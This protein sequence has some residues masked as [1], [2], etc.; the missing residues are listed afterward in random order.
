M[1]DAPISTPSPPPDTGDGRKG[2]MNILL[3]D[4]RGPLDVLF[5]TSVVRALRQV[6]PRAE[7][8]VAVTEAARD[9]LAHHPCVRETLIFDG[10]NTGRGVT[11]L[12]QQI[13]QRQ[14]DRVIAAH[15]AYD[16]CLVAALSG[17]ARIEMPRESRFRHL[18][19]NLWGT[20]RHPTESNRRLLDDIGIPRQLLR[21]PELWLDVASQR[22]AGVHWHAAGLAGRPRAIGLYVGGDWSTARW[23][24]SGFVRAAEIIMEEGLGT[25][26]FLGMPRDVPRLERITSA[27]KRRPVTL[28][29]TG[30]VLELA[31]LIRMCAAVVS[32]DNLAL[33]VATTQRVPAVGIYGPTAPAR[34]LRGREAHA[35][36]NAELPCL[37]CGQRQCDHSMCMTLVAPGQVCAALRRVLAGET[38]RVLAT[39]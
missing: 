35:T 26:V 25:P 39:A 23:T 8:D 33:H 7:I 4:L 20:Y 28:V 27:L 1:H 38:A 9:L 3:I 11:G 36:V 31:G 6:H 10:V 19:A 2:R 15:P 30:G 21:G 16:A 37:G 5:T 29:A 12:V 13:R 17:G 14:Y 18:L 32:G 34:H 22:A 24:A